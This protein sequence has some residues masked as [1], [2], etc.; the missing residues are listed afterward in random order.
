MSF[1]SFVKST[2]IVITI[3]SI[4]SLAALNIGGSFLTTFLLASSC[5]YVL[6]SFISTIINSYFKQQTKQKELDI[7]QNLSTIL[8]CAYCN[9]QNIMTFLPEELEVSQFTCSKCSKNNSVR[10][11]FVVARQTELPIIPTSSTGVSLKGKELLDN[12]NE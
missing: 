10:I 8:E 4:I 9:Q 3:S 1:K 12:E 11:Q 6:F 5:Q 2:L 7:L